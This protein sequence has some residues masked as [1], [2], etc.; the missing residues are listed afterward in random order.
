MGMIQAIRCTYGQHDWGPSLA[1]STRTSRVRAM[2]KVKPAK[3]PNKAATAAPTGMRAAGLAA[4]AGGALGRKKTPR[5]E[6]LRRV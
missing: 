4:A 3:P 6:R 2:R 1:I 5:A